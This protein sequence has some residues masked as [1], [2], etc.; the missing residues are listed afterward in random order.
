MVE[1][2]TGGEGSGSKDGDYLRV[3]FYREAEDQNGAWPNTDRTY[4]V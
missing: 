4:W 2:G 1:A 3:V